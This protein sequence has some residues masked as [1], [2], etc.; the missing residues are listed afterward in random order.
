MAFFSKQ[1]GG[2]FLTDHFPLAQ[3]FDLGL[4]GHVHVL[5]ARPGREFSQGL[6][7]PGLIGC[8]PIRNAGDLERA[9]RP[10]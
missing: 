7:H 2:G 5:P 4:Q 3:K 8:L 1:N 10:R 6:I 9:R